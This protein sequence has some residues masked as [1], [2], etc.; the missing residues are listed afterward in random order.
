MRAITV[1]ITRSIAARRSGSRAF[2]WSS[3]IKFKSI[4][5]REF[6][7]FIV[8]GTRSYVRVDTPAAWDKA[9]RWR[10]RFAL[11]AGKSANQSRYFLVE[12]RFVLEG[13]VPPSP[14]RERIPGWV[15]TFWSEVTGLVCQSPAPALTPSTFL[16]MIDF[17][18]VERFGFSPG[19]SEDRGSLV[20]SARMWLPI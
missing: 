19:K 8:I 12:G 9:R 11:I 15:A 3:R 14:E 1:E 20:F 10:D 17:A 5:P 7:K 4:W 6:W 2:T 18:T 16:P 13:T